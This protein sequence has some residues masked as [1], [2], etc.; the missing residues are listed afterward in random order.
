MQYSIYEGNME[1]LEKKL[2]RIQNKCNKYGVDFHFEVL[3]EEFK[4]VED[5]SGHMIDVR[6][7]IVEASG[8]VKHN[9]WEFIATVD[10]RPEGNIIRSFK[11]DVE[12]P[13]R[14]WHTDKICEHCNTRRNR[15]DTYLIHN[16]S[17]DEWKQ[18]G[19]TCLC[20]F[21]QGLDAED[22]TRYISLFDSLI[23]GE[24]PYTGVSFVRY[25][26]V[27]D[28]LH[29]AFETV[30]HFGYQST[31]YSSRSTKDRVMQY[32]NLVVDHYAENREVGEYLQYEMD[33]VHF[34]PDAE[35]N[36][37]NAHDAIEWAKSYDMEVSGVDSYLHNLKMICSSEYCPSRDLG[38]LISLSTTYLKHLKKIESENERQEKIKQE[39]VSS[40]FLGSERERITVDVK[41]AECV[42][43]TDTI[44]GMIHLYKFID[45]EGN[46][47]MW[48]TSNWVDV[49]N[50]VSITGTVKSHEIY[51]EVKQTWLTRCKIK[52][53]QIN[54]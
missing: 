14:Y 43:T 45:S 5:E 26:P 23:Q 40:E 9:D 35:N 12:V 20:E 49:D 16:V 22:V 15:K 33:E 52:T 54:E 53:E 8:E 3:G 34:N 18:V 50:V 47:L 21:T 30:K 51:Q 2:T 29:F 42:Y 11:P 37:K 24:A 44:Y 25:F 19:K 27:E 36:L 41:S 38:I 13:T 7:I 1:R 39:S 17:S 4:K 28:V 31:S 10:H 6:Y 32:Y 46:I 48:S